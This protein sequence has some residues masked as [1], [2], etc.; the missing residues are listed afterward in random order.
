MQLLVT[1]ADGFIG[2]H[3]SRALSAEGY[4]LRKSVWKMKPGMSRT[5]WVETG[6]IGTDTDWS[7]AI[8]GVDTIVHLAGR[9]H[10]LQETSADPI[11][12]FRRINVYATRHLADMAVQAGIRRFVFV[13]SIG[14]NGDITSKGEIFTESSPPRPVSLYAISKLEAEQTLYTIA[15]K[16]E[17]E[18]VI[19]RPTLVYGPGVPGNFLR[20]LWLI[21]KGWPLPLANTHNLRSLVSCTNLVN[22]LIL[23]VEH[24]AAAGETFLISDGADVSTPELIRRIAYYLG[25][26]PLLFPFPEPLIRVTGAMLG[27]HH[28]VDQILG[29]L[30]VDSSKARRLLGW[31]PPISMDEELAQLAE[32]YKEGKK[33]DVV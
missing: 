15:E 4:G 1:G 17:L 24:P 14:V 23:C 13:S 3:L 9:A 26:S 22:F 6:D 8:E 18:V 10:V 2:R 19:V 16:T 21:N 29:S 30:V 7:G 27:K 5:E 31:Q 28:M 20:L 11:A 33:Y 12:E 32:W 25:L